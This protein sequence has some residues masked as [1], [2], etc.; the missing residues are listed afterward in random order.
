MS[1]ELKPSAYILIEEDPF[2]ETVTTAERYE[3]QYI[4]RPAT[5]LYAIPEGYH[6]VA[7]DP[8]QQ[9]HDKL[10]RHNDKLREQES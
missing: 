8:T 7:I 2:F 10:D 3:K 5:P 1:N 4:K 6:L 9:I